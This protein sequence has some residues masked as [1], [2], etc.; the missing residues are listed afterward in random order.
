MCHHQDNLDNRHNH[1][2]NRTSKYAT[3]PSKTEN[4]ENLYCYMYDD[5]YSYQMT[6]FTK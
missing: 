6:P 4:C 1:K 2:N 3:L 5:R